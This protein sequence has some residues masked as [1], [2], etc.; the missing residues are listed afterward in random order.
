MSIV[1]VGILVDV[2]GTFRGWMAS[3]WPLVLPRRS[4]SGRAVGSRSGS[5]FPSRGV[6]VGCSGC[7]AYALYLVRWPDPPT[8]WSVTAPWRGRAPAW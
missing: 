1:S 7:M 6:P 8:W 2:Q 4:S 5:R 3:L